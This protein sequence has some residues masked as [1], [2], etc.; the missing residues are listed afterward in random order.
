MEMFHHLTGERLP[1]ES[2]SFFQAVR[3]IEMK[4]CVGVSVPCLPLLQGRV[5][6]TERCLAGSF[7]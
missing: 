3:F 6:S 1:R 2:R 4:V 7:H 5:T